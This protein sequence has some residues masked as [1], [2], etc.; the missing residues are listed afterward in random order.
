MKS[1]SKG[2]ARS[3]ERAKKRRGEAVHAVMA[4]LE[5][6][7]KQGSIE[8]FDLKCHPQ[9]DVHRLHGARTRVRGSLLRYVL[10]KLTRAGQ[11]GWD[12]AESGLGIGC[13]D[14]VRGSPSY[15]TSPPRQHQHT[16]LFPR[17]RHVSRRSAFLSHDPFLLSPP[18][19]SL[20]PPSPP[21][22]LP[23]LRSPSVHLLP[24]LR[25]LAGS[26]ASATSWPRPT[27]P[28]PPTPRNS[29]PPFR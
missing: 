23:L 26:K 29:S 17:F 11:A 6:F 16:F 15:I 1:L 3:R 19:S 21:L 28:P 14:L 4:A 8:I 12:P 27:A 13:W 2:N 22:L 7:Q 25:S 24:R 20:L 5:Q 10:V 9:Y 18:S